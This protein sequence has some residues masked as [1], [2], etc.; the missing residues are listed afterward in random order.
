MVS[1]PDTGDVTIVTD[2]GDTIG[3]VSLGN[4]DG[5]LS[6]SF[7]TDSGTIRSDGLNPGSTLLDLNLFDS[8][9]NRI[10]TFKDA[11]QIC[12]QEN[13]ADVGKD[14]CLGYW[15]T[16]QSRWRCEDPCL[17]S[18]DNEN[19][20]C[21]ETNHFTS[22]ALLL[23]GNRG[24]DPCDGDTGYTLAWISLGFIIG[25]IA[26]F[27][28]A[29]LAIEVYYQYHRSKRRTTQMTVEITD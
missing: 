19:M 20:W 2:G 13:S 11:V 5:D 29:A 8:N 17:E 22:F 27:M 15:D 9:G 1:I 16:E 23:N 10:T 4:T 28:I 7:V 26:I 12:I 6:V 3:T 14:A 21:G 18:Q 24:S 25:A